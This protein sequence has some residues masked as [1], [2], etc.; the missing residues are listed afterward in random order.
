MQSMRQF[1]QQFRQRAPMLAAA[2]LLLLPG[3]ST[4]QS[5]WENVDGQLGALARENLQE[6]SQE[7]AP[8]DFTGTWGIDL[9]TWQ[10]PVPDLLPEYQEMFERA[11]AAREQGE[12][13]NN[14]V[15]LCWPPG[16]PFMMNRV[17]PIN[18][19]QLPTSMVIISNFMNQVRW[20]YMDGREHT[21]PDLIIPSWNGES[22]GHWEGDT[23]VV[24]TRHFA[25]HHHWIRDGIPATENLT[26]VERFSLSDDRE[27]LNIEYTMTDPTVWEGEWVDTKE[28]NIEDKVDFTEVHCLPSTN[29][30]IMATDEEYR[31]Q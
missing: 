27:Q 6:H 5:M 14:D 8:E 3:L 1:R 18:I 12:V 17:W 11:Q 22:I 23:L 4:A 29:E 9:S 10:F 28:Y 24:E 25:G 7:P 21:D 19:I 15:G 16:M 2:T 20:I 26:I 13:F 30:G 31:V